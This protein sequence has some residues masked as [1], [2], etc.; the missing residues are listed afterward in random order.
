MKKIIITSL[1]I[2]FGITTMFAQGYEIIAGENVIDR[3]N[4]DYHVVKIGSQFWLL[5]NLKTTKY[6]N[7]TDIPLVTDE[8]WDSISTPAY[9]WPN[10]DSIKIDNYGLLYNWYAI[11]TTSE[12]CPTGWHVPTYDEW[13]VLSDYIDA[14]TFMIEGIIDG[15]IST[16]IFPSIKAGG[17]LDNGEYFT[18]DVTGVWWS[19]TPYSV[20]GNQEAI[21]RL[22]IRIDK[23]LFIAHFP[24]R[25][26]FSVRCLKD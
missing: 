10:N 1:T 9:C 3:D 20:E 23:K 15:S 21:T 18:I 19:S 16:R 5:E 12:L 14:K 2:L 13:I 4:N 26:G 17:R 7:G 6:N 11:N 8:A 24:N 25:Y 22:M